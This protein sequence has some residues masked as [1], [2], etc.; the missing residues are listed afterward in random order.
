MKESEK[1]D[2]YLD[3]VRKSKKTNKPWNMKVTVLAIEICRLG[4]VTKGLVQKLED[5]EIEWASGGHLNYSHIEIG[6]NTGKSQRS[7]KRL[8]FPQTPARNHQLTQVGKTRKEVNNNRIYYL[9]V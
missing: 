8:A 1:R 4:T 3:L 6:Q 2:E 5:T 7:L 9:F